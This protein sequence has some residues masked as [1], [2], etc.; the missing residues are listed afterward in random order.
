[1]NEDSIEYY[2]WLEKYR[3]VL[4]EDGSP[5]LY[6]TYGEDWKYV[7]SVNPLCVWTLCTA[8]D[9]YLI[10]GFHVVN[11]MGFYITE[12]PVRKNIRIWVDLDNETED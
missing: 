8:D 4:N 3:P 9:D 7:T 10:S 5:V 11:R 12:V 2:D 1:M 6:E